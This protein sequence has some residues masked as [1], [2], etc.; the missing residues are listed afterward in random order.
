MERNFYNEEFEDLIK[1]KAGQY[2]MYPSDKVWKNIHGSLHTRRKWFIAGMFTLITGILFFAGKE[3]LAP[4][5]H[6]AT[7]KK[8]TNKSSNSNNNFPENNVADNN[9]S[10][11][12]S[13]KKIAETPIV[14]TPAFIEFNANDAS[15]EKTNNEQST[16]T[17]SIA[18]SI[19]NIAVYIEGQTNTIPE[20]VSDEADNNFTTK[21]HRAF[22]S[23]KIDVAEPE[24]KLS[25]DLLDNTPSSLNTALENNSS[26]SSSSGMELDKKQMSFLQSTAMYELVSPKK[27]NRKYWQLYISP[28][29]TYRT[30]SGAPFTTT[31]SDIQNG[32][33]AATSQNANPNLY[34][35]NKPA[36]GFEIGSSILY[37]FTR[38]LSFKV[39]LQFNYSRYTIDAYAS[40]PQP[41]TIALNSINGY[42]GNTITAFTNIGTV[43]G[44]AA[45]N[46]QNQY[47][48][49]S[50]PVGFELRV[51]GNEKLQ[52]HV[53][54]TIQPT[55]LLNRDSYLLTSDYTNY[56]Q[57]PSLFRKWNVNG[58]VEAFISYKTGKIRWQVGPQFRYQL[59]S[60]YTSD[61]PINENLKGFGIKFGISK[62][63]F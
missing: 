52:V 3:L 13:S 41:A 30:L 60:T 23:H 31:K 18:D 28:I 4:S 58:A 48:Q 56:T 62:T 55:Y 57:A 59:L 54:A 40:N 37:R 49:L 11:L 51:L 12:S 35:N 7:V 8:S 24:K 36:L 25:T 46:L 10:N 9:E 39:G 6:I 53:G 61:Y 5:A 27:L 44:Q 14:I 29:V 33:I 32:P 1:Q 2:K 15:S 45:V 42:P 34:T 63:I 43:G 17:E 20:N 26:G 19:G 50:A 38:N 47:F 21:W 22:Y 16:V